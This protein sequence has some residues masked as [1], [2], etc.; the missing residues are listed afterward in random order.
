[1]AVFIGLFKTG[2]ENTHRTQRDQSDPKNTLRNRQSREKSQTLVLYLFL[3]H[4]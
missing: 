4:D 1:M 2:W 3:S